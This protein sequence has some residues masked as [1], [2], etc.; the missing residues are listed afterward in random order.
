MHEIIISVRNPKKPK[1]KKKKR[2]NRKKK[3]IYKKTH[4]VHVKRMSGLIHGMASVNVCVCV[5]VWHIW[6]AVGGTRSMS[7]QN[8]PSTF[9][10]LRPNWA[11]SFQIG[12][13]LSRNGIPGWWPQVSMAGPASIHLLDPY[14]P[15]CIPIHRF[16]AGLDGP[17]RYTVRNAVCDAYVYVA[18][19]CAFCAIVSIPTMDQEHIKWMDDTIKVDGPH[20]DSTGPA[21]RTD[22]ER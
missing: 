11:R 15:R 10:P 7:Q 20:T 16:S 13:S 17:H 9:F 2:M 4:I 6:Q 19:V 21:P 14:P 8:Q 22:P 3:C 5:C 1:Q 12:V 18:F